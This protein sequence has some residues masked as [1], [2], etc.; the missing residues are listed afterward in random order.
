[1]SQEP[2]VDATFAARQ[3][4]MTLSAM[5]DLLAETTPCAIGRAI[6][7]PGKPEWDEPCPRQPKDVIISAGH[8]EDCNPRDALY[9][10]CREHAEAIRD[11][12]EAHP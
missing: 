8:D 2:L 7:M 12:L 10:V 4:P 1:M 3:Q 11:S 6:R 5:I 9:L